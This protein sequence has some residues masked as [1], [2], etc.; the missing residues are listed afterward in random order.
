MARR[1]VSNTP[2]QALAL[3]NDVVFLEAAR[4]LGGTLATQDGSVEDRVRA[5]FRRCF[6][7]PPTDD[8]VALLV[9]FFNAQ[10]ER[11]IS[12]ELDAKALAGDGAG[13]VNERAAWT[14]LSRALWNF[15]EAIT[16]S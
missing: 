2:L 10:K 13:D 8:E 12:G 3:L 5:V 4:A 15:D 7:R 14:A 1:D 9:K 16:K 6:T 11:F